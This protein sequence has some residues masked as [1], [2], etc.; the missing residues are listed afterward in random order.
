MKGGRLWAAA[1][2]F[3][4]LWGFQPAAV[5]ADDA[6]DPIRV[7]AVFAQTGLAAADNIANF[8]AARLAVAEINDAG[9]L[10]GRPVRLLELDN[11]S[12]PIGARLAARRAVEMGAIA[13]VG[14]SWSTHS[15]SMAPI[16]QAAGIPMISPE[17][18]SPELTE[19]GDFIFRVCFTD[20]FQGRITARFAVKELGAET[21]VTLVNVNEDDSL[22]LSR[23]FSEY[24]RKYG[25]DL[26]WEGNYKGD[27]VDF[28]DL[29]SQVKDRR[30]DVIFLPG[31]GRD[32]GLIIKQADRMGIESVF[33]GGDGWTEQ[34]ADYAGKAL[35][36]SYC[37]ANWHPAVPYTRSVHLLSAYGK[38]YGRR[39]RN[40]A[41]PLTYDAVMVLADAVRRAGVAD[42]RAVRDALAGTQNFM[43]ATGVIT[44]DENGDPRGKDVAFLQY[45]NGGWWLVKV[46]S[47]NRGR[48]PVAAIFAFTGAAAEEN[49]HSVRGV[50]F[51]VEEIN[52]RGGVLDREMALVEIDNRSTPIGSKVAADK[53]VEANVVAILGAEWSSHSIAVARV[54]QA[55]KIPMISNISTHPQVTRIG[56]FIFRTCYTDRF[57]G[58]VMG[59]F[60]RQTLHL[61]TAVVCADLTSDYSMGLADIFEDVFTAAGGTVLK[62]LTYKH[63]QDHFDDLAASV[64][65]FSPQAVFIPGHAESGAIIKALLAAKCR[66]VFLGGDGWDV[67]AFFHNGGNRISEGYYCT[68]WSREIDRPQSI[69]FA[70]RYGKRGPLRS[71]EALGFDAVLL[72]ADAIERAGTF[73]PDRVR[74]A[75]AATRGFGGVTGML[76]FDDNGDPV[77]GGVIMAIKNGRTELLARIQPEDENP[78]P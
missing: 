53:A 70:E 25:G 26:L 65:A 38:I 40:T 55:K 43:G 22:S 69:A 18:S 56:D 16:L 77:K 63:Q 2:F 15:L 76:T 10:I 74:D 66:P 4:L 67:D 7:A 5:G 62:K 42:S 57:V 36:G 30:P 54:A 50:R 61:D 75:L 17:S 29:L 32:S 37:G 60:A 21:A 48:F 46:V 45:E 52:R 34:V 31:H 33:I 51:G 39:I 71:S 68:H 11:R 24:F 44:M 14:A 78:K 3:V 59:R 73:N 47:A 19:V 23:Y 49:Y 20:M 8:Q 9:G 28:S 27:A 35:E 6:G 41:V 1:I 72:L 13:V 64:A 12:T 58:R